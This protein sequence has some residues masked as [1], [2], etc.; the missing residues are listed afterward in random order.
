MRMKKARFGRA[1]Y[2]NQQ[3]LNEQLPGRSTV[4]FIEAHGELAPAGLPKMKA[5]AA[6]FLDKWTAGV[7]ARSFL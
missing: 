4:L 2:H 6:E 1:A 7:Q 5:P 3:P